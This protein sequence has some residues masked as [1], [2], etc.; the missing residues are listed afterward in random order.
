MLGLAFAA[1]LAAVCFSR[2]HLPLALLWVPAAFYSLSIAYGS[3]PIYF[4]HWWPYSYYNVRYGLQLLPAIA[5]FAALAAEFASHLVPLRLV[6]GALLLLAMASYIVVW[7]STPICLREAEVNGAGRLAFD[8]KLGNRL[9]KLQ[10]A[11][12]LMM[13]CGEHPGAIQAA[14]IPFRRVLREGNHPDWEIGLSDP[15]Q[16]ADYLVAITGDDVAL[17]LRLF[18]RGLALVDTMDAPGRRKA[19]LYRSVR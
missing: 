15:A 8:T 10:P 19:F 9:K 2:K 14:G 17:A 12:T 16:A 7:H 18:P 3:V 1:L 4:P 5:V 13:Y 11:A 6:A